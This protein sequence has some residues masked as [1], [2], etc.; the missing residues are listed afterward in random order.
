V[1]EAVATGKLQQAALLQAVYSPRQ[2]LE[3]MVNFW[4][5]RFNIAQTN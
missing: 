5:D 1:A 3:V 4:S 2:L